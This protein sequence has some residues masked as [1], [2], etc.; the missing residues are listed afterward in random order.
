MTDAAPQTDRPLTQDG[1][2]LRLW[3]I[4]ASAYIFRAYHALPPLTRKSDGLPVGAVQGYSNM[5]WKLLR[6]MKGEDG[7]THLVAIFD[8]SEKT[9]RNAMYDQYKANRSAPPEDLI[10]QFPLVRRATAAFGV[11]CV[12]LPGYEADDLI[13]TYACKARDRGGEAVIVSSDKDLMQLIGPR[14]VMWDP[15]KDRRLAEDAVM[16]KF[17]VTP[18]KMIDLQALIG[19]SVDNVPGA[20]GIGPKTAAQ[21]LDEY[22]DLD[23]LLARAHEIKQPKRRETLIAHRD[24]IL[25][26]R[27]LVALSC[28]APAPEP[29]EDFAVRDPDPETLG[30]FLDEMEFRS[31][32][33][34]V[35]DGKAPAKDGSAFAARPK[36]LTAPVA[37]P[38]FAPTEA[39]PVAAQPFD[40]DAYRCIQTLEELDAFLARAREAGLVGFDT[41]TD[42]LSATHAGLC[43]VSLAIGPNDACY[44]P[45]THEHPPVDGAGG[46]DFGGEGEARPPL[47]QLDKP[48]VLARLKTLLEDPAVLKVTQNGKYD[49]AV[50]ARRGIRVAPIDDTMLI[51]YV[52]DGGKHPHGMDDLARRWLGHDPIP[53]KQVA[54]TG[55]SQKSFKHVEL[56]PATGYAAEDADVTLR[57]WR[58]LKP[59]LAEEGLVTVYE[60]LERGMPAVLADMERAGIR[61]DPARLK[62]LSS[63]FGMKM[64]E[65]EQQ[66]HALAGRPFNVGSP[67][68]IGDILFGELDLP[69]GKKTA[70]GQWETGAA[71]LEALAETHELPRVLLDWRQLSKLKGTYTDALIEAAD[72]ETDRVHTSYQLAAA[73]TG[74]LASSDP[75]LQNIPI[76]TETG[77][78]IRKAFIA[79]PG[80]VLIS[81]DYSQIELRLLAHIGDIPELKRAFAAG[82]DIHTAT[83]SEMFGVP[84][85]QMDPETRRRAKAINFGIVYGISAFGLA[86]QLGIDQGE[87]GAYIKTYFERFPG[88][89]SYMD[90]TRAEVRAAGHVSTVFGRRIHIPA[91]QSKSAAER[92]FGERAAINAPIQGAAADIIR[93]AMI[94]MP[95][96]LAEA[97]LSTRMLLQV[98]DELVF[99]APEAEAERVLP[100]IK[101]VMERAAEPAVALSV[102]LVVEARAAANWDEAH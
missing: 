8:H 70:S 27:Q 44:I 100:L 91:I 18:D 99:E 12:E 50:M 89:R 40:H 74:R 93:R 102:P 15:M 49:L 81:A 73:S 4:D 33:A 55:K 23:T 79:A 75:N 87:A 25:L 62:R 5:L 94:R 63:E 19:D 54:G 68:Q 92:Q 80:H 20:P 95:A 57:L 83:A 36:P 47:T 22:G 39:A 32:R 96:A 60:T 69:G 97:G 77:R 46:L 38:R 2:A 64:A 13:A 21:L 1:P 52:L 61:V 26:S 37:T 82:I 28:D 72:P 85:E 34:R 17:G 16:E 31:L 9:F 41:E 42:A 78:Q 65:L 6:D 76:R 66:A 11:P 84:V 45:L 58:I 71:T 56:K 14:V 35:G 29:I 67:R 43:G 7:P 24:Q 30:A 10:P 90:A 101:R 3:M 59:R 53:F 51:S 88:I 86:A 98:H 48:T